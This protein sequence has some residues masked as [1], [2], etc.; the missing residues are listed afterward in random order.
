VRRGIA[1]VT[2]L[3]LSTLMLVLGL[4]FLNY[5]EADYHFAA[6]QDRQQQ[7]YYLAVAGLEYQRHR[8][9]L[10]HEAS[11]AGPIFVPATNPNAFFNVTVEGN[12]R[13][14]S[15]GVVQNSFRI[16]ATHRLVVEPGESMAE[17]RSFA[18]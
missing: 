7:A 1:L 4:T 17:A 12:G 14:H 11:S 15:L 6:H 16:L 8:T 18:R 5:L 10:L 9:D 3:L 13:V 2:V